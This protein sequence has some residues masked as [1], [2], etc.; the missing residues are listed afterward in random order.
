MEVTL[1]LLDKG[2][3]PS[4]IKK[5]LILVF[6]EVTLLPTQVSI[7]CQMEDTVLILVFMEVTLL[8][9]IQVISRTVE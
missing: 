6:M 9:V 4:T 3:C 7:C 1:L 5:V 2:G 8:L